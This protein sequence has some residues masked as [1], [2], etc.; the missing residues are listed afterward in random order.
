MNASAKTTPLNDRQLRQL[1]E[2]AQ[3]L[4]DQQLEW[5]QGYLAGYRAGQSGAAPAAAT[6]RTASDTLTIVYGSQTGNSEALAQSLAQRAAQRGL[7]TECLDLDS[8][9]TRRLKKE[10]L[11]AIIT[12][13][14]GEGEPPDNALTLFEFLHGRKA[15]KLE[16]LRY[17]VLGLG[18]SSYEYF[19]QTGVDFDNRLQELGATR[20]LERVD[21]DVD[22][23]EPSEQWM[24]QL[25][26]IL[27][28]QQSVAAGNVQPAVAAA[29]PAI[30]YDRKHPFAAPVLERV[31]L[32]GRGSSKDVY[33]L[34]FSLEGSGLSYK[35]GDS[36]GVYA[37]ND[38]SLVARILQASKLDGLQSVLLK[39]GSSTL[40]AALLHH[41]ELTRLTPPTVKQW[42]ALANSSELQ[43][44]VDDRSQLM[45]WLHGRD[46]L[47]LI[48]QYPVAGLTEQALVDQ[49]RI[50]PPRL[51]SISSSQAAVDDEVHITVAAVRY[52]QGA[53]KREGVGSTWLADRFGLDDN[54][55]VFIDHNKGFY[56]PEDPQTPIIM[57]GPGTGIAPFRAFLQEREALEHTGKNWLFFGDRNFR[58]DFLYQR[59]WLQWR[60]DG[61]LNRLDVA[62][63]RDSRE[64]IYVQQRLRERGAELWQWL[65][66]GAT[67]YVCGDANAMAPDVN[68]ALLD[69]I[70]RHGQHSRDSATQFLR[71][72][73]QQKRYQ[74]DIY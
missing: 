45:Q 57:I 16:Q 24:E 64:K 12:S 74:R 26:D 40:Q 50:L 71:E 6:A 25:L 31:K 70:V 30:N 66:D 4:N 48:E 37:Q 11:L 68:E 60:K 41:R 47:D 15:P 46:V 29:P 14:H 33:H 1:E 58:T 36:L 21:C 42:A 10:S 55:P 59:E 67:V 8:Y 13:T 23:E 19:C 35:P 73:S 39:D 56:L 52:E 43:A 28:T 9:A 27:S 7:T 65:N 44:L 17:A 54:A 18:D 32:N 49:L 61:L 34:E 72:L 38:P 2:L 53:R 3:T 51:Y 63:S 62:F 20:L 5:L 22:F 69:I